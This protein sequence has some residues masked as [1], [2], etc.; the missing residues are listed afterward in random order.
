[1]NQPGLLKQIRLNNYDEQMVLIRKLSPEEARSLLNPLVE[2]L[3]DAVESGASIGFL[4]P[5][6]DVDAR[7]YWQGIFAEMDREQRYL[8][9]A[10]V[11]GSLMGT[12]QLHPAT[13]PN[14]SHRAE[15][16]KLFV[17]R[18]AR[19]QGI[20][21]KLMQAV[22]QAAREIGRK[23]LVLDTRKGDPSEQLYT[24][25]GYERAG[26]IPRYARAASGELHDTVLF[27][28]ELAEDPAAPPFNAV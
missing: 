21:F 19:R 15:V 28:K 8:V 26:E 24:R 2:L 23:L 20:G 25:I 16:A 18:Q 9:A 22:E 11:D 1:L 17:H 10:I 3:Q 27:Y 13:M 14:G 4:P 5:V 7:H 12:V 6:S